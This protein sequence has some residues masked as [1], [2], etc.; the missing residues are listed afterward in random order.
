MSRVAALISAEHSIVSKMNQSGRPNCFEIFGFDVL[1]DR[2][3]KPWL[4]EVNV[5]CSLASSSPLDRRIKE[6]LVTDMFH[7]Y[8]I[9]PSDRKE[10]KMEGDAKKKWQRL[11]KVKRGAGVAG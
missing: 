2:E 5:A 8:G 3:L 10:A 11:L 7:M 1:L 9:V 4:I 6:M